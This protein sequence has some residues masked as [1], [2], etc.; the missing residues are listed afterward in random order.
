MAPWAPRS[1]TPCL[2]PAGSLELI[3]TAAN[4]SNAAIRKMVSV[5]IMADTRGPHRVMPPT[6]TSSATSSTGLPLTDSV[7]AGK[8][9]NALGLSFPVCKTVTDRT[10]LEG[11]LWD[12][13]SHS[14]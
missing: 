1:L 3:S 2:P 6:R 14:A 8:L 7:A 11:L 12:Q 10:C 9:S 5:G 13:M 4:H